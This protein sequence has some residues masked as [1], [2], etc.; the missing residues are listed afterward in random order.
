MRHC[1]VGGG[2]RLSCCALWEA[3]VDMWRWR[4]L[5]CKVVRSLHLSDDDDLSSTDTNEH[6]ISEDFPSIFQIKCHIFSV[7]IYI[8]QHPSWTKLRPDFN[9][10]HRHTF[11]NVADDLCRRCWGLARRGHPLHSWGSRLLMAECQGRPEPHHGHYGQRRGLRYT[12]G[13]CGKLGIKPGYNLL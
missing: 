5:S 1:C 6:N 4:V 3:H 2:L 10:L 8:L 12:I 13:I 7:H 11:F 9:L